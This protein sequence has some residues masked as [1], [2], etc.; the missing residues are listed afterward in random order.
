MKRIGTN[1]KIRNYNE[2]PGDLPP[3]IFALFSNSTGNLSSE[4]EAK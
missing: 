4:F 2:G 3:G 1:I